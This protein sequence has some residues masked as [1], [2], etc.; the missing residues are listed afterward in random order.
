MKGTFIDP[1]LVQLREEVLNAFKQM[2][3]NRRLIPHVFNTPYEK[4][5]HRI[6]TDGDIHWRVAR[7]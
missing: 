6:R 3:S 7:G 1:D 4:E 2:H 5:L